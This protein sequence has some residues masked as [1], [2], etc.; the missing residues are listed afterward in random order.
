[1]RHFVITGKTLDPRLTIGQ[2]I[3][4]RFAPDEEYLELIQRTIA[5]NLEPA[6]I[7]KAIKNWKADHHR[8]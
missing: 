2:I 4:L 1:M 3:A 8:A 6:D 7:K 5:E